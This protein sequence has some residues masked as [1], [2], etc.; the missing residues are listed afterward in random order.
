[1]LRR[2]TSLRFGPSRPD[3]AELTRSRH[4]GP[5]SSYVD[6]GQPNANR[7]DAS[8]SAIVRVTPSNAPS[9]LRNRRERRACTI[10]VTLRRGIQSRRM[11][12][13]MHSQSLSA[14]NFASGHVSRVRPI[15]A[16]PRRVT[17]GE[18]AA[19]GPSKSGI[20]NGWW[21][22]RRQ[23]A[24]TIATLATAMRLTTIAMSTTASTARKLPAKSARLL[25]R[26]RS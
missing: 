4:G 6:D 16:P 23:L 18:N 5:P 8:P 13:E 22:M 19:P 1:M 15:I 17:R 7:S 25:A 9:S 12:V 26:A 14:S 10:A 11:T 2:A 20:R 3:R 21:P 24:H